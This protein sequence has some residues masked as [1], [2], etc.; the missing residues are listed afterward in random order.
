VKRNVALAVVAILA[1][2]VLTGCVQYSCD[3]PNLS[4]K[5][6]SIK[7]IATCRCVKPGGQWNGASAK[8]L[9]KCRESQS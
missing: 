5:V 3:D 9:P 6:H 8:R 1:G 2:F 7:G 4:P